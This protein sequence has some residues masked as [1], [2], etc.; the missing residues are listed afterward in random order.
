MI[1]VEGRVFLE[2]GLKTCCVGIE[3]GRIVAIKKVLKGDEHQDFGD[4]LVLPG[5]IDAHV[6]FREPGRTHKEDFNT[7]SMAA[8]L[9]GVTCVLDMPNNQ[10]P[11]NDA[12]SLADKL[13]L[14]KPK[15]NVDFGLYAALVRREGLEALSETVTGFKVYL[16]RNTDA[17]G[18]A[19][20][21]SDLGALLPR[22]SRKRPVSIHCE[23]EDLIKDIEEK[24]LEDH[25]AARPAAAETRA[26]EAV[27][28][29]ARE[30]KCR[31]HIA[32]VSAGRASSCSKER[33]AR[34]TPP[35]R[36]L[37]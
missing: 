9:G 3:E 23:D 18:I 11:V 36:P 34:P 22:A 7:G 15:A 12:R 5:C 27:L 30:A 24:D 20:G 35:L 28:G 32:H 33:G 16:A 14:V 2:K 29:I 4:D 26:M 21:S 13:E 10:P 25:L 31:A 8:A 37:R 17:S 19:L 6:H 1:V